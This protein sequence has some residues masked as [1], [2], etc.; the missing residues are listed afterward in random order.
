MAPDMITLHDA[1]VL[2]ILLVKTNIYIAAS[3]P[4]FSHR[5]YKAAVFYLDF[6]YRMSMARYA[7][8]FARSAKRPCLLPTP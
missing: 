2:L 5:S 4:L 7:F 3:F 1:V 8:T 6:R